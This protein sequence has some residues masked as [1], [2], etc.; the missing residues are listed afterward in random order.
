MTK[1][2][3]KDNNQIIINKKGDTIFLMD[4]KLWILKM[5]NKFNVMGAFFGIGK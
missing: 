1:N 4:N 3:N 5:S 2:A